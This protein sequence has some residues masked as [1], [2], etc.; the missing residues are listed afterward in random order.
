[1]ET[2]VH[3]DVKRYPKKIIVSFQL[4]N[5]V[6]L[7]MSQ[8]YSQ[9]LTFFYL[10]EVGLDIYF[11]VIGMVLYMVYN[12]FNDPLLG[13][14]CDKSKRFTERFGK[15]FPFI[16]LGSIPWCFVVIFI[17]IP[18]SVEQIGQFGVFL[19]FLIFLCI[20]DTVFSLYDINRVGLFPDKFR[21]PQDRKIGGTVTTILETIGIMLG[22]LIP[23]LTVQFVGAETGYRIQAI[24]IALVSFAFM[25]L[26]IPGV[27]ETEEMRERRI[28]A[29]RVEIESFFKGLKQ[30]LR[31]KHFMGYVAFYVAY[32]TTMGLIMA[33][34]PFFVQDILLMP[35]IGELVVL[36]YIVAV[37]IGAPLWYKLSSR[38]GIK[39]TTLVGACVLGSMG[40]PFL[41]IP[42]G[43]TGLIFVIIIFL[44]A[45]FFDAAIISMTMPLFSSVVDNATIETGKRREGLYNGTWMFFSRVSL[46]N[47]AIVFLIIQLI[48]GYQS[49]STAPSELFGLRVQ[50]SIVPFIILFT[51]IF[52]FWKFYRITPEELEE[53]VHKLKAL[54][55]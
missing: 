44:I 47:R 10:S 37:I 2:D 31:D 5:L 11:Y 43:S 4:G 13:Y 30:A 25:V 1:M 40:I 55:I 54:K 41:F 32:T 23:V 7:M 8:M 46:A 50:V 27:R 29:D 24:I 21:H 51:G 39:R 33:S 26:M 19:W 20:N 14:L 9:Q 22:V 49:G 28:R 48:F 36:F 52:L 35:K 38:L 18:P 45:G 17:Y 6:N 15:R 3:S 42:G 12:M 34:I 53:N 16:V